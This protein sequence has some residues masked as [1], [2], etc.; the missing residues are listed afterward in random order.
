[1]MEEEEER[2][3]SVKVFLILK[4]SG[5]GNAKGA[6]VGGRRARLVWVGRRPL[7][8]YTVCRVNF[9]PKS[10]A[11]IDW[12]SSN[13]ILY[14]FC[15]PAVGKWQARCKTILRHKVRLRFTFRTGLGPTRTPYLTSL[16]VP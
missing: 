5:S 2:E 14:I 15:I 12:L 16:I 11:F 8:Q 13:V 9:S 1:M 10:L 3:I 6:L 7:E 4:D